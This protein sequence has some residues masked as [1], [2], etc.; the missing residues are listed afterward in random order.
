ML[1]SQQ[2]E[3]LLSSQWGTRIKNQDVERTEMWENLEQRPKLH[4]AS[5]GLLFLQVYWK[6]VHSMEEE[7]PLDSV[8]Q[9]LLA[10]GHVPFLNNPEF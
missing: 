4:D 5:G 1:V 2:A 7:H 9:T 3:L 6:E 8:V 10:I